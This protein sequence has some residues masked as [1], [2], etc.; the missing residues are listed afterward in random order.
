MKLTQGELAARM[1]VSRVRIT[2]VEMQDG[3]TV[4]M[5]QRFAGALDCAVTDLIDVLPI[6]EPV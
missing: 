2:Q 4:A 6:K 5:L 1:G 3:I